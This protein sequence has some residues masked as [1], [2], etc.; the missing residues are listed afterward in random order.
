MN[1]KSLK[2][3]NVG[4]L[5]TY[6]SKKE[7]M[8]SDEDLEITIRNGEIIE[9]GKNLKNAD[10]IYDCENNLVTPGFVDCHTH[11]VFFNDRSTEFEMR[12]AGNT[13]EQIAAS[14]GGI[15]NSVK[16]LRNSDY[17]EL[18]QRVIHR[19]NDFLKLGTTTLEAK[20]GY[21][22]DLDNELKSLAILDEVNSEHLVDI[23]PTFMGAHAVPKEYNNKFD[24][25]VDHLCKVIIP[26]VAKQGIA[27]Y[28]DV[29]CEEGYFDI[30]QS[31]KIL[32]TGL[33]LG[34]LPRIHTDEFKNIGGAQLASAMKCVSADHLMH[35]N[36][37]DIMKMADANVK[38]VL[39]PGTTFFLGNHE[40][41]P[42]KKLKEFGLDVAVATD[43]NPGSCNIQS[44]VFIITLSLLYMGFDI[45]DA[46]F[47]STYMPSKIL[48]IHD[49]TGSIEKGK[50]ADIIV[51]GIK[52]PIDIPYNFSN[53]SIKTVIKSGKILF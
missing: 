39:L 15:N 18:K 1:S 25:Y 43:Y 38:A 24:D 20:S 49:K 33:N 19:M 30:H 22:L 5:L 35:V 48:D 29:F 46:I 6:N 23:I 14:G 7:S 28:N 11:P 44:M 45:N 41:A 32:S 16:S 26:A 42:Y 34:L 27:K 31:E 50:N 51:W 13:Y 21:G 10:Q 9:I 4:N 2:L 17:N 40:Y 37:S 3:I 8:I 47:S 12:V 53:N 36:D 52:K